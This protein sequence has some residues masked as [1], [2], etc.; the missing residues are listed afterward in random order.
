MRVS[1]ERTYLEP[2]SENH[3]AD[4]TYLGWLR[5]HEVV[6]T[7]NLPRYLETPVPYE[8][9][10][11]YCRNLMRSPGDLFF[12]I[13][14][15]GNGDFIGTAKAGHINHYAGT[16]DI[17][18]M[19]GRKDLW[20]QGLATDALAALCHHLFADTGL[21]RLTAGV[22]A[23]NPAMICVFEKLGF[24]REGV[25]REQDRLGNDYIDHIHLGCLESEFAG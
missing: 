13:H 18:I 16:A 1:G 10:A 21:R 17:G 11:E 5:D 19:L 20:G 8:E 6:S 14:L 15:A 23:I 3:L 2:F 24:R 7:L 4:A 9:V 12:A 22:M 25:F